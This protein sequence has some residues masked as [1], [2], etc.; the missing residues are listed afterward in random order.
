M[1]LRFGR[2]DA[3]PPMP[4]SGRYLTRLF[5]MSGFCVVA[6]VALNVQSL[7]ERRDR[8]LERENAGASGRQIQTA[9]APSPF[10]ELG[11]GVIF[12]DDQPKQIDEI[13]SGSLQ[14]PDVE[15][16]VL[17]PVDQQLMLHVADKTSDRSK[18]PYY[19]LI[20]LAA[21]APSDLLEKHA[22][23]DITFKKLWEDPEKY[24]GELVYLKGYLRGLQ[25][26]RP[27]D[28]EYFNPAKF[29]TLYDGYLITQDSRPNPFI[30]VV[31]RIADG[32]PI[33]SNISENISF[34]G[35]FFKLWNY[36]AADGTIR[37]APL[38]IGQI[39]TWTPAPHYEGTAQMSTYL[40][41]AFIVLV[42]SVGGA[43]WVINRRNMRQAGVSVAATEE[44]DSAARE[45][46]AELEKMQ[47]P[48]P[49]AALERDP[50]PSERT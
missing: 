14:V 36:Q 18:R 44:S 32:M 50:P 4:F 40:A 27:T 6:I 9:I 20:A 31:P 21:A 15:S 23:R 37:S 30:I 24:R 38:L 11:M 22:R 16:G 8:K 26:W 48:D 3:A 45:G 19:H 13:P 10:G 46:L 29:E 1:R 28:E 42:V 35:Y 12:S 5:I 34:A 17:P 33:G 49:I 43:I 47:I 41:V 7:R 2:R 39:V 25:P